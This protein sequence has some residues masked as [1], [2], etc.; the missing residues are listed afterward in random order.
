MKVLIKK[1]AFK[2]CQFIRNSL[3][4]LCDDLG[5]LFQI[6]LRDLLS[7]VPASGMN[8]Q[9]LAAVIIPVDLDEMVA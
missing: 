3:T 1:P 4:A 6:M 8:N 9:I 7:K 2:I 5:A